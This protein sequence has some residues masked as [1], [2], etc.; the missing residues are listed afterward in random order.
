M[1]AL[2]ATLLTPLD[3][4]SRW[5]GNY[6]F[7]PFLA[8]LPIVVVGLFLVVLRW[9]ASRA[10][11]LSYL[12]AIVLAVF[13][14]KVPAVQV[15]VA[16]VHGLILA[17]SLLYIIFGAILLLNTLQESGAIRAIRKGFT[18][19]SPDR[20]VQVIIVAW[21]FGSFIEGSAGFGTPAAVAV[22]LLVGLGFPAMAAVVA[23]MMIQST[24]VSFGALGT[25]II[26]GV[27]NGLAGDPGVIEFAAAQGFASSGEAL[28]PAFLA[29]IGA[30]VAMLHAVA[31][32]LI[33]L[34]VVSFMTRFF[35]PNRSFADGLRIW[36]FAIFA[37]LSMTLP[38]LAVAVFLGP[39][40]PSLIGGLCGL[41]IVVTAARKG[42]LMPKGEPW[43]FAPRETWDADWNGTIELHEAESSE[44]TMSLVKA[45]LPYVFVAGLLVATRVPELGIK[46][47]LQ[48]VQLLVNWDTVVPSSMAAE[49]LMKITS[50]VQP[51]YLPGSIFIVVSALTFAL[52]RM[53]GAAYGRAWQS[54]GK[55]V[56]KASVALVFTVPMV[57]VFINSHNG[58]GGYEKMPLVLAEGVANLTGAAWPIFSPVIG[59]LGAFVAGSN[60]ISNMMFSLFQFNV[61]TR[62]GVSP[63]WI[64]ALQAIG[65]AAGNTICVHNVVAASAVVGLIGK[66]GAVIRKTLCVFAYYALIP[67]C[68]GYAIV[69]SGSKG[70]INAGS[71]LF[72][73]SLLLLVS[74]AVIQCRKVRT[75]E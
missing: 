71:I 64:V 72:A 16:S 8:T 27:G 9:P 19:I 65:G 33:P 44:P 10:M 22:P 13:V 23:G 56:L 24:P 53:S 5:L 6:D 67:G 69:W 46:S 63:D 75:T 12:T 70:P 15:A 66:E 40:F 30:K 61:G 18:D 57:Q 2:L 43:D 7:L 49:K 52:H 50:K 41:A 31:G 25:P 59:G 45:W 68:L 32:T 28:P 20:R 17:A 14:W 48:S 26:V 42:F 29:S 55:T 4:L 39:E 21:L 1:F 62:I 54:S 60:T 36:P 38:Y 47:L 51:L 73:A 11:P 34:F 35:G 37:A 74:F 58:S 3:E